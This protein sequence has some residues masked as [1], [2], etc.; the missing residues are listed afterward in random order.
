MSS[1]RAKLRALA[2]ASLEKRPPVARAVAWPAE[3]DP[4]I[5]GFAGSAVTG[6]WFDVVELW[7]LR[8]GADVGYSVE[9]LK[10]TAKRFK[11]ALQ[12]SRL[13]R[14]HRLATD[15]EIREFA[16]LAYR[17]HVMSWLDRQARPRRTDHPSRDVLLKWSREGARFGVYVSD[18]H[19]DLVPLRRSI[20]PSDRKAY[21]DA[22][23]DII[24]VDENGELY[25]VARVP[26]GRAGAWC[27]RHGLRLYP[28]FRSLFASL[29]ANVCHIFPAEWCVIF[30]PWTGDQPPGWPVPLPDAPDPP[31]G[32]LV[33]DDDASGE[34]ESF[35]QGVVRHPDDGVPPDV[36][37]FCAPSPKWLQ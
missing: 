33:V 22:P 5:L 3:G 35:L 30:K 28:D 10:A 34:G 18:P 17:N 11:D 23:A 4:L 6:Y 26:R 20:F 27:V 25:F 19:P 37:Q 2:V 12:A 29:D 8:P 7:K 36:T 21:R 14:G 31:V 24:A 15:R 16:W 32:D 1:E 13:P 9:Q